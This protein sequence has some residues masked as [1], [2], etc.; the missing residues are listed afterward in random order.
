MMSQIGSAGWL[1]RSSGDGVERSERLEIFMSAMLT[2]FGFIVTQRRFLAKGSYRLA[3]LRR[4]A[5]NRPGKRA[6]MVRPEH[7]ET[8][9][10]TQKRAGAVE[11]GGR[12]APVPGGM[13]WRCPSTNVRT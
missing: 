10:R 6:L 7:I 11:S 1:P 2:Y 12:P 9:P 8:W 4:P 5:L 3:L 13:P